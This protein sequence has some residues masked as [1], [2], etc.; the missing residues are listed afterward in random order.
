MV[1]QLLQTYRVE[2]YGCPARPSQLDS[3]GRF[4]TSYVAP[5]GAQTVFD[6]KQG[7]SFDEI[8]DGTA[9]TL[10]ILEAAGTEIIWTE[11]RDVDAVS[12]R[13]SVNGPGT[14]RKQS[15]SMFSSW[16]VGGAQVALAD[17]SVKF[18][19]NTIDSDVLKGLLT[20]DANDAVGDF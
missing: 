11:P 20:K 2:V 7:T 3:A 8:T 16:H 18:I 10:L 14:H 5:T 6:S 13:I 15:D 12:H 9:N 17:G 4:L 1:N 19:S